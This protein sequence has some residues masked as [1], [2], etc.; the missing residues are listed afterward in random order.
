[1]KQRPFSF[2]QEM[3][4]GWAMQGGQDKQGELLIA[5]THEAYH[6]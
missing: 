4:G 1:M 5:L 2:K 3:L 6:F